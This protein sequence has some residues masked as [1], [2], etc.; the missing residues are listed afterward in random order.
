MTLRG[1]F[2]AAGALS[3]GV[4]AG[5]LFVMMLLTFGDVIMRSAFGRPIE[6]ATELTRMLMALTVFA[7]LPLL[8]WRGGHITVDLI[9]QLLPA[10]AV[11]YLDAL[12]SLACGALLYWPA[13]RCAAL[14]ERARDYGDVTE[15]LTIPTFYLAWFITASA[16]LTATVLVAR[17]LLGLARP[18]LLAPAAAERTDDADV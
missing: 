1:A 6:A 2:R 10:R 12:A 18:E 8:S 3:A 13:L 7:I 17:G 9:D 4:A 16:W 15:Y 5:A 11:R 14:A